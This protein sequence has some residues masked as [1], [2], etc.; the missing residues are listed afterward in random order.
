MIEESIPPDKKM[1][2][3]LIPNVEFLIVNDVL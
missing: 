1:P 2:N 3:F